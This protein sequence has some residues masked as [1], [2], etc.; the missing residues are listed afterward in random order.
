MEGKSFRHYREIF[1][2]SDLPEEVDGVWQGEPVG[3]GWFVTLAGP[4]LAIGGLG[5]WWGKDFDGEGGVDNIVERGGA[6]RRTLRG[7]VQ[8]ADSLVDGR[9][10]LRIV[11]PQGSGLPWIWIVDELRQVGEGE[12]LGMMVLSISWLPHLALPFV[13]HARADS[14]PELAQE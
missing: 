8:Q 4:S 5:G 9:S 2:S 7:A 12:L 14:G 11:Y 1:A 3:P 10:C 6:F 13:L